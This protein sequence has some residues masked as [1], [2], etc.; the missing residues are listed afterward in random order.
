MTSTLL[1]PAPATPAQLEPTVVKRRSWTT[2]A[3]WVLLAGTAVLYLWGLS[4]NGDANTFYAAAVQA[5]TKSWKAFFFGSFDSANA[6]TVDKPPAALWVMELSGRIFGFSSWS[7]LAPQ[8]LEGVA[9]VA[10]LYATVKRW[11][12]PIAGLLAGVGLAL[13]P[14]A[15]LM[16][17]FNNPD[18]LLVL[19]LVAGAYATTRAAEKA[20]ARWL[21]LAGV[22]V[23][24]G[25]LTKMMQAFLVLPA[26]A[27]VYLVAAPTSLRRRILHVLGA[28]VAVVLSAGWWIATVELWPAASRPYIGGS[29]DNS[30]LNL[31]FG[32]N[33]LGRIFGGSGNGGGGGSTGGGGGGANFGGSTGITR[34]FGTSMGTQI[35]WLLP[36][37]LIALVAGLWL[38][39][40]A[41]RTDRTRAALLLWGLWLVATGLT[42]SFM[43][44]TI[45]PY[46]TVALAPAIAGLVAI[47][48]R[49]M[50]RVRDTWLGRGTLAAMVAVTGIW[51][52]V[53]LDRTPSW[54]PEVRWIVL[55]AGVL[56]AV[57]LLAGVQVK[58]L[59]LVGMIAGLLTGVAGSAAYA[60]DT[61]ATAHTGSTPTA[62]PSSGDGFGGMGGSG[63]GPGGSGGFPGGSSSSSATTSGSAPS[64]STTSG[65]RPSGATGGG[66]QTTSAA[67]VKL[68]KAAG[69]KW[70][71]ATVGSQSAGPMEL[72]SGT[73]VMAI[74]GFTGSDNSPTLAQFKAYVAAG[75]IHYFIP[76]GGMGGGSST[77]S[78]TSSSSTSSSS[79]SSSSST[80]TR[81]GMGGN[82]GTASE[83]TSWVESHYKAVTVD[84][85]TVYD[86]T[87]PTS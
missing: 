23:G 25:F 43:A 18:A 87:Q 56:G 10:L 7:M 21:M 69:T 77:S 32:Y 27:V 66:G 50:W 34:L 83:I 17:R 86:L 11:S 52:Y 51:S 72:S 36:A 70:S 76:G 80:T 8:A 55:S 67:L 48:G 75:K 5:G 60:V 64:G 84:G 81:G 47:T 78:S 49:A 30:I 12:G 33:G 59:M 41:P 15:V 58:K 74:G 14:V 22:F 73:A 62:G 42:F 1:P 61:A 19:L 46:Y 53:L 2:P 6:I 4:S 57:A 29:T 39:R 85:Q 63:G 26:F 20:S 35:S 82:S 44:G 38:T 68:L 65:T 37:A 79:T 13:T 54:Q 9:A 24:F 45:H 40:R 28:G 3:L 16:F 31:A 71:A